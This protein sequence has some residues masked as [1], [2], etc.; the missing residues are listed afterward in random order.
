M[1][2]NVDPSRM[3]MIQ[4]TRPQRRSSTGLLRGAHSWL[5][6]ACEQHVAEQLRLL[7]SMLTSDN[8]LDIDAHTTD[9]Q[10]NLAS[11]ARLQVDSTFLFGCICHG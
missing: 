5:V 4:M 11:I 3:A 7:W 1:V 2:V 9:S 10:V 6:I 8:P